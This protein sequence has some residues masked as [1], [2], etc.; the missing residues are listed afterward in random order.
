MIFGRSTCLLCL[1][2]DIRIFAFFPTSISIERRR[3]P[4]Q[5]TRP[6]F[7]TFQLVGTRAEKIGERLCISL[8]TRKLGYARLESLLLRLASYPGANI[9]HTMRDRRALRE[10]TRVGTASWLRQSPRHRGNS[11]NV[12]KWILSRVLGEGGSK[13]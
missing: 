6:G 8:R 4:R 10:C 9:W 3:A 1:A 13:P 7:P 2:K 11:C 5:S 12:L